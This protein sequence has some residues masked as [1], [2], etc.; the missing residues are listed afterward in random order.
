[1]A[2]RGLARFCSP[3]RAVFS[4]ARRLST[5]CAATQRPS[6]GLALQGRQTLCST[7]PGVLLSNSR[8]F[9]S[10]GLG[11]I[12][13][14]KSPYFCTGSPADMAVRGLTRCARPSGSLLAGSSDAVQLAARRLSNRSVV[15]I[16]LVGDTYISKART[17]V[18]ALQLEYMAV[19][20]IS[21]PLIRCRIYT[22]SGV[23]LQALGH[24][25]ILC[26]LTSWGQRGA[27]GELR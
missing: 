4:Q 17:S 19:R 27:T 14:N 26:C 16:P 22:L 8:W 11:N 21:E 25:T 1:M 18:R 10:P 15:L 2:V 6:T 20:G 5:G 23:L 3:L 12:Y 7:T 13:I 9:S 24:L